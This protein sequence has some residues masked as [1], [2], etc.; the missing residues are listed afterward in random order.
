MKAANVITVVNYPRKMSI[1]SE[2][3]NSLVPV[4]NQIQ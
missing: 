3:N 2:R 4:R 1:N